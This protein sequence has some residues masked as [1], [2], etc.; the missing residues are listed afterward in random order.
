MGDPY[1]DSLPFTLAADQLSYDFLLFGTNLQNCML[2]AHLS[3]VK[4]LKGL[5]L[6]FEKGYGGDMRTLSLKELHEFMTNKKFSCQDN[7]PLLYEGVLPE[8]IMQRNV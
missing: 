6:E 1:Y 7:A 5:V 3:K 8:D 4:K 2:A